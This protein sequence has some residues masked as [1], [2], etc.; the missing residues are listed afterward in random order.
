ML[1]SDLA[2][3]YKVTNGRLNEQ[4][5]G[6]PDRFPDDF[7][8]QLTQQ[9]FTSLISQNAISKSDRGG[10]GNARGPLL[11]MASRCCPACFDLRRRFRSTS[12]LCE[13]LSGCGD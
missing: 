1:D 10:R 7:A 4:V 3:L 11:S 2:E 6:N 13:P 12:R 5:S 9:E 8:F